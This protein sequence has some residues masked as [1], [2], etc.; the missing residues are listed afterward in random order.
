MGINV[1][2][3]TKENVFLPPRIFLSN[4][5]P[6]VVEVTLDELIKKDL[7]VQVDWSGKLPEH[8]LLVSA[9]I[10][11][12]RIQVIGGNRMLKDIS[13]IYTEEVSLDGINK[14]GKITVRPALDSLSLTIDA[15]SKQEITVQYVVRERPDSD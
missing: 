7:P 8:L 6:S 9:K 14:I 11:P 4:V 13:T 2:S 15:G 12:E 10:N 1:F 5:K 3:L